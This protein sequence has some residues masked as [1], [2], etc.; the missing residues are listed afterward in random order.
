MEEA[1]G[2]DV[3]VN[4]MAAMGKEQVISVRVTK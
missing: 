1:N 4:V 3:I 2:G